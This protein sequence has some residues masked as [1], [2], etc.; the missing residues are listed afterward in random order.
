MAD[1]NEKPDYLN[2]SDEDFLKVGNPIVASE[3]T[4]EPKPSEEENNQTQQTQQ[5]QEPEKTETTEEEK[6]SPE[7]DN[8]GDKTD[9]VNNPDKESGKSDNKS[10]SASDTDKQDDKDKA[11]QTPENKNGTDDPTS[12]NKDDKDKDKASQKAEPSATVTPEDHKTFY[13]SII[14][15]P[16]TANGKKVIIKNTDEAIRLIQQGLGFAKKVQSIQPHMKTIRVLERANLLDPERIAF[17]VD[18]NDKNPEAIKKLI[19]ESGI[20]PIDLNTNE[21]VDYKPTNRAAVSD[22]D[23]AFQSA[24]EDL[25]NHPEGTA[26]IRD[27]NTNWDQSSKQILFQ[28]PELL[29]VIQDQKDAGI[30][31]I[32]SSEIDRQKTLG[33]INPNLPFLQAYKVVGDDLEKQGAFKDIVQKSNPTP[34][35]TERVIIEQRTATPA[36]V[37]ENNDKARAASPSKASAKTAQTKVNPLEL[38]DD[39]F[40]KQL[41]GRI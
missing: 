20:D 39:E 9:D 3:E 10:E 6:K 33:K 5:T 2:M 1:I 41:A 38:P 36:P 29:K 14:G 19:K 16:I 24:L 8:S 23:M 18:L 34:A 37:V 35:P 7:G 31:Q 4:Q 30:Y 40:M 27:I 21:E 12:E 26:T 28:N 11:S 15:K 32:I 25:Q 22:A 17:L 13:E